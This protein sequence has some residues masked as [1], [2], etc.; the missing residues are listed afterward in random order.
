MNPRLVA[1]DGPLKGSVFPLDSGEFS[2][3][4]NPNSRLCITD[5]SL[6]R[7]HCVIAPKSGQYE[8]RDLDSRNGTFVNGVPVHERVLA[9]GD[10]LQIGNSLFLFLWAEA[11]V[12]T[13]PKVKLDERNMLTGTTF[14]L[15]GEDSAICSPKRSR[16]LRCLRYACHATSER[17]LRSA[18]QSIPSAAWKPSSG[19]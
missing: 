19:S 18:P 1:R 8:L 12:E 14:V 7:Q 9:E 10:Q 3:G 13:S 16:R 5:P 11:D 17:S 15:R 2:V 4:R 6:S